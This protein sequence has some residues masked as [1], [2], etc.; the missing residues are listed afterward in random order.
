MSAPARVVYT[1]QEL[2]EALGLPYR[3]DA[4]LQFRAMAPL[5]SAQEDELSFLQDSKYLPLLAQTRAGAL[6]LSPEHAEQYDGAAIWSEN[7]YASFAQAMQF[8]YPEK[9]LTPWRSPDARIAADADVDPSARVEDFVQIGSGAKIGP[10]VWLESGVV[11]GPGV[12]IGAACHLYPGVKVLAESRIA[13]HCIIHS[14]AV[15]GADGF[16]FAQTEAGY[17]KIPQVGRV[18]IGARV[19]I[20]ANTCIDRGALADTI[21]GDGVKIDNL[22]QIGH[23]V[24]IGADTVIAGQTGIAGSTRIGCR[25]RIGGQVGF[26]GHINIAD[27]TVIAGQSAITHDIRQAGVYSGVIPAQDARTWRRTIAQLNRLDGILRRLRGAAKAAH[28]SSST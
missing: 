26:A 9:A 12:E 15:I 25:C 20:G 7:P 22:V 17:E 6:I 1:L 19:E 16:G 10:G 4:A 14:N 11:I 21:L 27:G 23:N 3:G 13:E 24:V 28:D 5:S 18:I 8:L 2:A